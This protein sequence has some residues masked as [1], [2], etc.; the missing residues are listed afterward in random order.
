MPPLGL[1]VSPTKKRAVVAG[2]ERDR[3]PRSPRCG[4][5]GRAASAAAAHAAHV[6]SADAGARRLDEARRDGVD[7]DPLHDQLLRD[8]AREPEDAGLRGRVVRVA[9][10]ALDAADRRDVDDRAGAARRHRARGGARAVERAVEVDGEHPPPLVVGQADERVERRRDRARRASASCCSARG[11]TRSAC[12]TAA[13]PALLTQTS[14][15][16]SAAS[17]SSSAR[18]D[19]RA[20]AHVG[21]DGDPA[22]ELGRQLRPPRGRRRARRPARPRREAD[23]DRLAEARAAAGDDG[24]LAL[25]RHGTTTARPTTSPLRSRR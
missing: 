15:G 13:I 12:A 8:R 24:D 6:L 25:E 7:A 14:T 21:V 17:A 19:R 23:A 22:D 10:A 5:S 9:D 3:A 16:P 11:F 2:E 4:R 1:S 18:V 20:V